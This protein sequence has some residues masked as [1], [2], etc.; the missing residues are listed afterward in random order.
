MVKLC[1]MYATGPSE[2]LPE[3][4][5]G[6]A[7]SRLHSPSVAWPRKHTPY[8]TIATISP[9]AF[10][11]F[12]PCSMLFALCSVPRASSQGCRRFMTTT[13]LFDLEMPNMAVW[14]TS[15]TSFLSP[16]PSSIRA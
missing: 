16:L 14:T 6:Y 12:T 9:L 7:S 13:T 15:P 10:P 3:K 4:T 8:G 11:L 2:I 1:T 5:T